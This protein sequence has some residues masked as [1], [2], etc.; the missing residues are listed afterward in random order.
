MVSGAGKGIC[1]HVADQLVQAGLRVIVACRDR[2][3]GE[4]AAAEPGARFAELDLRSAASVDAFAGRLAAEHDALDVLVND[5]GTAFWF[6]V[7]R[8]TLRVN[9]WGTARLTDALLPLLRASAAAGRSPRLV[10][11]ASKAG[12]VS[13]VD[14]ELQRRFRAPDLTREGLDDLVRKFEADV[15][16]GR[17]V[18]EGWGNSNYGLAQLAVTAYTKVLARAEGDAVR[19]S[20][21]GPGYCDVGVPSP[22]GPRSAEDSARSAVKLALVPDGAPTGEFW[23]D[24]Q[25]AAERAGSGSQVVGRV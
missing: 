21:C 25:V 14:D 13:Q 5:V 2:G 7:R 16:A 24:E 11:V 1:W 9:L 12:H 3:R 10:N 17:N 20:A 23:Q 6:G 22:R 15:A 4:R 8:P 19:V 18:Q